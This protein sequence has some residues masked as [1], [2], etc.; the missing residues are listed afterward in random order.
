MYT[1]EEVSRQKQ[2]FW[3]TFGRYMRPVLSAEGTAVGWLNYKTGI[4]GVQF[5]MEADHKQVS[6]AIVLSHKDEVFR[7]A[8]YKKL[9]ELKGMLEHEMG[10]E[11][12]LWQQQVTDEWGKTVSAVSKAF[13]GVNIHRKEDWPAMISFLKE[14]LIAL[15]TFWSMARYGFE[16]LT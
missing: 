1:K 5:K 12:W 14:R 2:A 13:T 6:I 8:H 10:S 7:S 11:A 15:D 4:P 9:M 3:T 16:E